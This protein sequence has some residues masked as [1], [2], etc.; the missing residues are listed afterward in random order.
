MNLHPVLTCEVRKVFLEV[1]RLYF[2]GQDVGLVEEEDDGGA[3]EPR[4]MDG[5]VE[6]SQALVHAI[7][8]E[9]KQIWYHTVSRCGDDGELTG[10][11]AERGDG[12]GEKVSRRNR[13]GRSESIDGDEALGSAMESVEDEWERI[14][15][16]C[17]SEI[18]WR[19]DETATGG[20]EDTQLDRTCF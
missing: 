7:L 4:R 1:R 10:K 19:V 5:G 20:S 3:V 6:Q 2:V 13:V 12:G 15:E 18:C 9:E 11:F 17:K 14:F 8:G 16:L